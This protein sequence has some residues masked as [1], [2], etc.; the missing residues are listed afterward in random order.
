MFACIT[1]NWFI[2]EKG[3]ETSNWICQ[4]QK[5]N[6]S[7]HFV[8]NEIGACNFVEWIWRIFSVFLILEKRYCPHYSGVWCGAITASEVGRSCSFMAQSIAYDPRTS[9]KKGF[10]SGPVLAPWGGVWSSISLVFRKK[11]ILLL[12]MEG[13]ETEI[14]RRGRGGEL[15]LILYTFRGGN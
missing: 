13:Y 7:W 12:L 1:L 9:T 2:D 4:V 11:L 8:G 6:L 15:D 3:E 5:K 14:E 10:F